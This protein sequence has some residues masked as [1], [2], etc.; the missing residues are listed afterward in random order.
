MLSY[1][2]KVVCALS[3]FYSRS[4]QYSTTPYLFSLLLLVVRSEER[5]VSSSVAARAGRHWTQLSTVNVK[6]QRSLRINAAARG[7]ALQCEIDELLVWYRFFHTFQPNSPACPRTHILRYRN[8]T[9]QLLR[10][11]MG[12]L[13]ATDA[14]PNTGR[15]H[16]V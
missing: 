4:L 16:A 13:R 2:N 10:Q 9:A 14:R 12:R 15:L 8:T 6:R 1:K 7:A 5:S 11:P 3:D